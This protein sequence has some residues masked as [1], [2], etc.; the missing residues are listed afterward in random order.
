M[1]RMLQGETVPYLTWLGTKERQL[2]LDLARLKKKDEKK[3]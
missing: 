2:K 3:L 1:Q